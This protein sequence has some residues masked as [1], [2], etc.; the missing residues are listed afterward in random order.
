M[1]PKLEFDVRLEAEK[2]VGPLNNGGILIL[3]EMEMTW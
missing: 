3:L 2:G 1:E